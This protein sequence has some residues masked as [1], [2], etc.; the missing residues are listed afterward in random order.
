MKKTITVQEWLQI[1]AKTATLVANCLKDDNKISMDEALSLTVSVIT[2][3][4][5]AYNN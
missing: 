4:V 2:D 3:I 5:N 1:L